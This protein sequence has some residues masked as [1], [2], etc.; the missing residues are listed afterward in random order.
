M[1]LTSFFREYSFEYDDRQPDFFISIPDV[2]M[3][4]ITNLSLVFWIQT[5]ILLSVQSLM[6]AAVALV[7]HT[8]ILSPRQ[9][10]KG[11][12][13]MQ[14]LIV[15]YGFILP[16]LIFYPLAL[17]D[18]LGLKNITLMVCICGAVPNLLLL[19]VVEAMVS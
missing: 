4:G 5:F 7:V 8:F 19:R 10:S 15:G 16:F 14:G 13:R 17:L 12:S 11:E 9:K 6:N 1:P 18:A 2:G 3:I